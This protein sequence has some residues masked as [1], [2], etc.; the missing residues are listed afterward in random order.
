MRLRLALTCVLLLA[1][2]RCGTIEPTSASV[3]APAALPRVHAQASRGTV[4]FEK[5]TVRRTIEQAAQNVDAYQQAPLF[6]R[7]PAYVKKV[8]V[9]VGDRVKKGQVLIEL[10]VPELDAELKQKQADVTATE[11]LTRQA[12]KA[13]AAARANLAST[14]AG[15]NEAKAGRQ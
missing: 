10:S 12:E 15:V 3:G 13:L 5:K 8:H 6:A 7:V 9:D 1:L 14:K 11:S 2:V 4:R